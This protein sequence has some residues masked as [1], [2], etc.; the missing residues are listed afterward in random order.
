[1]IRSQ[2]I[3]NAKGQAILLVVIAHVWRGLRDAKLL[4]WT[5]SLQYLDYTIYSFHM[6]AFFVLA[7]VT[8]YISDSKGRGW[9]RAVV[10]LYAVYLFWSLIQTSLMFFLSK[11]TTGNL[12]LRDIYLI[13]I[14]PNAQFW[15]VLALI[16]FRIA[17]NILP[18][19][20]LLV[21]AVC[22]FAYG[23]QILKSES[24]PFQICHFLLYFAVGYRSV[25]WIEQRLESSLIGN[26]RY[27]ALMLLVPGLLALSL[28]FFI[29]GLS[30][31]SVFAVV[32]AGVGM[33]TLYHSS[34][35]LESKRSGQLFNVLGLYSLPIYILHIMAASG[36]RVAAVRLGITDNAFVLFVL[37]VL[38][39]IA[40]PIV[41]YQIA[42][43][44][45]LAW[46]FTMRWKRS[47]LTA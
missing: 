17:A 1:L 46:L 30:Y 4:E 15:F 3:D 28:V 16:Q 39:G 41:A 42:A 29:S 23:T 5:P 13:P 38:A 22:L 9:I 37:C 8:A 45:G 2:W 18:S 21:L 33:L 43:R 26:A 47:T 36:V 7:G 20:C 6:P 14:K 27:Q 12:T 10:Q 32:L 11:L 31:D 34:R 25:E 24:G 44:V 35:A 40:A 19:R